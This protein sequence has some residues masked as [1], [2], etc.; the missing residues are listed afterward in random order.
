M[1]SSRL[2]TASLVSS[3]L[4]STSNSILSSSLTSALLENNV[5]KTSLSFKRQISD[6]GDES[7]KK[8]E[9]SSRR[10]DLS[11]NS[12]LGTG[13]RISVDSLSSSIL[14]TERAPIRAGLSTSSIT[15]SRPPQTTS[16]TEYT[17]QAQSMFGKQETK[18][19]EALKITSFPAYPALVVD[20]EPSK[21][22]ARNFRS[23]AGKKHGLVSLEAKKVREFINIFFPLRNVSGKTPSVCL[24]GRWW[25]GGRTQERRIANKT[26]PG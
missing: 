19:E 14:K 2:N 20:D 3:S 25:S 15:T 24:C 17:K 1:E 12:I 10:T 21:S 22:T 11:L 23:D 4:L 16:S 8:V 26:T 18:D 5:L 13:G 9:T 7:C 6:T